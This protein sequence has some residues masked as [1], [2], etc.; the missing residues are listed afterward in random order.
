MPEKEIENKKVESKAQAEL[1]VPPS[2]PIRE[3]VAIKADQC[4]FI[5]LGVKVTEK[6]TVIPDESNVINLDDLIQTYK[7][8]CGMEAAQRMLKTG[9]RTLEDFKDPLIN[10]DCTKLPSTPQEAANMAV[11]AEKN[12]AAFKEKYNL[13][14]KIDGS[15]L[16][17]LLNDYFSKHP[18]YI[19]PK[20]V[21]DNA[22]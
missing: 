8:S 20:E 5:Q 11:A 1:I 13:P 15:Q 2:I 22:Q 4:E 10:V 16:E 7:D 21:T 12:L 6:H 18:E 9:Q 19:K 17:I 14:E 3:C